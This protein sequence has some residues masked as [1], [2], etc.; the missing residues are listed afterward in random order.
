MQYLEDEVCLLSLRDC[1]VADG[2]GDEQLYRLLRCHET[3][4][5]R[6][7]EF[8]TLSFSQSIIPHCAT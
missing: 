3:L 4:F 5:S 2:T 1:T 8:T 7:G 6:G